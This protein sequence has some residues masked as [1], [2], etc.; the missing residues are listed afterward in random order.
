MYFEMEST[1]E[2]FMQLGSMIRGVFKEKAE[3]PN[4]QRKHGGAA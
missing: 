2:E 3:N 4:D 1:L